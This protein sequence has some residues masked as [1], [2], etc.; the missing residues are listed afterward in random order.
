MSY[1]RRIF[2]IRHGESEGNIDNTLYCRMP[3]HK[4]ALTPKGW[5]QSREAGQKLALQLNGESL[6]VY[7]SPFL[8]TRQTADGVLS[9]ID[10]AQIYKRIEDPR[11][12]EQEFGNYRDVSFL[13]T[14]DKQRKEYGTFFYRVPEGES[15][16][17][18][19]D[20]CTMFLDTFYRDIKGK[21]DFP[22]N[23]LI[24]THGL[25]LRL[26]LMRWFHWPVE[27]IE[28]T[29]NLPNC[30]MAELH[31][32]ADGRHYELTEPLQMRKGFEG[33]RPEDFL[34]GNCHLDI[35]N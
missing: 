29:K 18:V 26:M 28:A 27:Y 32:A 16:A 9:A 7:Q 31:L 30:G 2:L 1:P 21:A 23:A 8:R 35:G 5:E 12:R 22:P 10:P 17:D 34:S 15:G 33:K 24:V 25:T 20:R 13:E 4:I 6:M 11:L 3:D 14:V 19:Y